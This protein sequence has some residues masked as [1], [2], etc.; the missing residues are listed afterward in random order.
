MGERTVEEY[1]RRWGSRVEGVLFTAANK[2]E[3]A[4]LGKQ[5]FEDRQVL[6]PIDRGI[7]QDLHK[8]R[9][10]TTETGSVRFDADRDSQGHADRTWALF[11]ALWA[12]HYP[13]PEF[14]WHSWGEMV[15][16]S[17]WSG[18]HRPDEDVQ[19]TAWGA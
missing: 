10:L 9:K 18:W 16:G 3:L 14:D 2:T 19:I 7:R 15:S 11:L 5:R 17:A 6:I 4:T 12:G 8:L 1:Q 13:C